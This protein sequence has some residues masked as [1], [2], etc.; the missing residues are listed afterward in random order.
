[1]AYYPTQV[2]SNNSPYYY[3]GGG[4]RPTPPPRTQAS[5]VGSA[6]SPY[7]YSSGGAAPQ[8]PSSPYIDASTPLPG[9]AAAPAA[10]AAPSGPD[11]SHLDY[12]NDPILARVRAM[13]E[14]SMKAAEADARSNR[15]RLVIG[16]GDPELAGTL[17]LGGDVAKQA[18][19]N[20]FG[21]LQEL[22]RGKTRRDVFDINRPL[23][24]QANL[25]YSTERGKQLAL[26]GE[27][28]LRDRSTAQGA[29][30]D[31]L[32]QI[33][34][35]VTQAKLAAQAQQI[36]AEQEAYMRAIQQAMYSAGAG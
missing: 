32:A 26:S 17:G 30:Q 35:Q 18:Q 22:G 31:K 20:T 1:M 4:R 25:F 10:P 11:L 5:A 29:V 28:Y 23:S 27:Q 21:T 24:D 15:T 9:A 36:Q 8:G 14:E 6:N 16:L 12:S 33:S 13:A 2:G 19:E 3:G 7:Y 34:Q